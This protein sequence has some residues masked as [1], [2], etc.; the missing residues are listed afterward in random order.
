[1]LRVTHDGKPHGEYPLVA[2]EPVALAGFF[3]RA[4][5]TLRLWLK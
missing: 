5:D 3:G 4:W 1:V 2:L